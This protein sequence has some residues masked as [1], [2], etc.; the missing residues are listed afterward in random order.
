MA[1]RR[2][3]PRKR[4]ADTGNESR[5]RRC[6]SLDADREDEPRPEDEDWVEWGGQ[7]IFEVGRTSG[8]AP[9]GA[10]E[11]E[12]RRG[13][14]VSDPRAGWVRA[15]GLMRAIARDAAGPHAEIEVGYVSR[16]GEGLE[17]RAWTAAVSVRPDPRGVSGEHVVLIPHEAPSS[18]LVR[19]YRAEARLLAYL[20][21]LELPFRVPEPIGCLL[22]PHEVALSCRRVHGVALDLRARRQ[23]GVRPWEVIGR[24]AA[25][26]HGIDTAALA[27]TR[28][29]LR[30]G[31][32]DAPRV[33]T[34]RQ[35]ALEELS[36]LDRIEGPEAEEARRWARS[37]LPPDEP[38]RLLHGDLLGQ[39]VLLVPDR[40]RTGGR[41]LI[42][43]L[44]DWNG[45]RL[46]DPAHDLAIVTRG[47]RRPFG[48]RDGL[49]R[50]LAAYAEHGG[51]SVIAADVHLHELGLVAKWH[52]EALEGAG[53]ESPEQTRAQLAAVL[54]RAKAADP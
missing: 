29:L 26:V 21:R 46:G 49:E 14:E 51:A 44:L 15:K 31:I 8:G 17:R 4:R 19:R 35:H 9:Y 50:L 42:P 6:W 36:S 1:R 13:N 27:D 43:V 2:R 34:R 40:E 18:A 37:H 5:D 52:A 28:A 22:G 38:A 30:A 7:L 53:P 47:V 25:A 24:L 10:T 33:A 54:R 20:G 39:N 3:R 48:L 32:V 16:L 41:S 23:G 12:F 11:E 45:H